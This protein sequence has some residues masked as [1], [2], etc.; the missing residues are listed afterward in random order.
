MRLIAT[1]EQA[2]HS[3]SGRGAVDGIAR[4]DGDDRVVELEPSA[5][6]IHEVDLL[7][8]AVAGAEAGATPWA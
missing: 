7:D 5:A 8:L 6:R 1:L 2:S 3:H 4:S